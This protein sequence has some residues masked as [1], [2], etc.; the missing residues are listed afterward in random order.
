MPLNFSL[1]ASSEGY[2]AII[3][4]FKVPIIFT[5]KMFYGKNLCECRAVVLASRLSRGCRIVLPFGPMSVSCF[6]PFFKILLYSQ[7][8]FNVIDLVRFCS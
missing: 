7:V 5:I 3:V 6:I 1:I 2:V 4:D 8:L